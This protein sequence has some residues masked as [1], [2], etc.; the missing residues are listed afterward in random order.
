MPQEQNSAI[1]VL[2]DIQKSFDDKPIICGINLSVEAG[3]FLTLLGPSGC[4]KTTTLRII[5]GLES[6]DSGSVLING[7]DVTSLAPNKRPVNTVFQNYALFPHMTVGQNIAYGLKLKGIDKQERQDR[8]QQ[9]LK[10]VQMSEYAERK[11]NQLSGGQK[12]RVAIARALINQPDVLL[13]DEPLGALDLQLRRQ[14]QKELKTWQRHLG[15]TFV[16]ITHDQEEA[17]NMSSRIAIMNAGSF[18]QVGTPEEVYEHPETVFAAS[19]IGDTNILSGTMEEYRKDE[20]SLIRIE[21][22]VVEAM[23]GQKTE[24][25][26]DVNISLRSERVRY[27]KSSPREFCLPA[28]VME[29]SY[30]GGMRKTELE[31]ASGKRIDCRGF[32]PNQY[33][34]VGEEVCV[35]WNPVHVPLIGPR[36]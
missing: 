13:L 20:P 26:A 5:D 25:G 6:P 3:E 32:R 8:V 33:C 4:G 7:Q 27:D 31:L 35:Y 29:H 16:Y 21:G 11:P 34:E 23:A 9:M 24:K 19:F 15:T 17:L 1:L 18:E 28:R 12:Q 22:Q 10:T 30:V 36:Q 2:E 14:M